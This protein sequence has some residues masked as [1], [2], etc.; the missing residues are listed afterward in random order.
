MK[1]PKCGM[2]L[3]EMS[4]HAVNIDKCTACEGIRLEAGELEALTNAEKGTLR[5]I[6]KVFGR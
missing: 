2:D 6:L 3:A 1:C 5:S 4:Y